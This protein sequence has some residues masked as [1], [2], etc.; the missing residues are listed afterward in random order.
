[1]KKGGSLVE[2]WLS[3]CEALGS[4]MCTAESMSLQDP[5]SGPSKDSFTNHTEWPMPAVP[6]LGRLEP[7]AGQE[8][9]SHSLSMANPRIPRKRRTELF[10][11]LVKAPKG[12]ELA[13]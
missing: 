1:M 2:C 11:V 6:A 7:G 12:T 10:S 4:H 8:K 13:E 9:G 5:I 3:M